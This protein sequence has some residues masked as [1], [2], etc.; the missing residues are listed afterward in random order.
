MSQRPT[1]AWIRPLLLVLAVLF[2]VEAWIWR[3]MAPVIRWLAHL[4]P[5]EAVKQ[6]I[7]RYA[8]GLPPYAALLLFLCPLLLLEPV[9]GVALWAYAHKQWVLGSLCLLLVKLFGVGLM[10]FMFQVCEPQLLSIGWF[11]RLAALFVRVK[12][13]AEAEVAPVKQAIREGMARVRVWASTR[14]TGN[15]RLWHRIADLR[16]RMRKRDEAAGE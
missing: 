1:S 4:L 10:A 6:A 16:R 7:A 11:A 14:F 3:K 9:E 15:S 2:L 12:A 5:F 13:W 8:K